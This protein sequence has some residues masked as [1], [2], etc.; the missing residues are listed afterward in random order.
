MAR[1]DW[2]GTACHGM[3]WH[4]MARNGTKWHEM[5]RHDW[6]G[7]A[8]HGTE[9][10]GMARNGMKWHEMARNARNGTE[11]HGIIGVGM[12]GWHG[13]HCNRTYHHAP[14]PATARQC[15]R[16]S[17]YTQLQKSSPNGQAQNS[18]SERFNHAVAR[19]GTKWHGLFGLLIL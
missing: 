4:E 12:L 1:H 19:N 10:H 14:K 16:F 3:P 5:A 18:A 2:H 6:H 9:W 17:F 15:I 7:T 11:W 13:E 8:C